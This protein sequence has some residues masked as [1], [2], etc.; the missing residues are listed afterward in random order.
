[1]FFHPD[2]IQPVLGRLVKWGETNNGQPLLAG[3]WL[4]PR[5][6]EAVNRTTKKVSA[7]GCTVINIDYYHQNNFYLNRSY[8]V[9]YI[10]ITCIVNITIV[11]SDS[12]V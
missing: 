3:P 7:L 10:Q 6:N 11:N 8:L 9:F 5:D 12:E 4:V 1:M 2:L